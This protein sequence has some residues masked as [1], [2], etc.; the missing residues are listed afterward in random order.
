MN[1]N[2]VTIDIQDY[3]PGEYKLKE[4]KIIIGLIIFL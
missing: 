3:F 2:Q 1:K 4:E